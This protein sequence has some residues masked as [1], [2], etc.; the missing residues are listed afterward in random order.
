M[1]AIRDG[2]RRTGNRFGFGRGV[3][4]E[5]AF[6]VVDG[7][8]EQNGSRAGSTLPDGPLDVVVVGGGIV[9]LAVTRELAA[10]G[11][12]VALFDRDRERGP[13][14][15]RVAAGMLA[16]VGEHEFGEGALL[17]MNLASADLYPD[18]VAALEA[19]T[20]L[21]TGYRRGGGLHVALDGDE[22]AVL[23]RMAALQEESGLEPDRLTPS[24]A[25]ELEPGL[26][27]SIRSAVFAPGDGS[28]DPRLLAQA[29]EADAERRG[30]SV[31][32]GVGVTG[33]VRQAG[34][35]CG[36]ETEIGPVAAG[37]V[38]VAAGAETGRLEWLEPEERPPV[39]PVKGQVVELRTREGEP[40]C[41]RPVVTERVYVVPRPDG[42]IVVG[43]TVEERGWDRE[44][45]FGGV[46]ELLREAY[47]VLPD[48]AES[49][50]AGALA[51]FRPGTP[52]NLPVV[53]RTSTPG[54]ALAT[55][56]YRNGILLAPLT[57]RSVARM[58]GEGLDLA[59]GMEAADP[60]R[61]Q[62][63]VGRA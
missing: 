19:D 2:C 29:L 59:P 4:T 31:V 11:A 34:R 21:S 48:L 42:R 54:L 57:G 58:I 35:A 3:G 13:E 17:P 36:V 51:G 16:P 18:L 1:P 24:G 6:Q 7:D 53:G 62:V 47:R 44:V 9:G 14:A 40:A 61:F 28:V 49:Y 30:A 39:R 60:A 46:F 38:V 45:T 52:D 43:A 23:E 26:G 37:D 22:A 41:L 10:S 55:G 63:A 12:S 8:R 20:G 5:R 15:T 50:F 32:R 25:R 56:H 27:P 33:L